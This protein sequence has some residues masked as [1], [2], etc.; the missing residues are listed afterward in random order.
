MELSLTILI[1]IIT[2]A[3]SVIAF[4]NKTVEDDLIFYPPAITIRKQWYRF[5]TC[6]FIHADI[7]HLAFNMLS[8]YFFGTLVEP[9]F[10]KLFVNE[11]RFLYIILYV[12]ALVICLLPTYFKNKDNQYYKSLGASGAVSAIIFT[13]IMI[14]PQSGIRIFLIPFDIPGFIFGPLYLIITAIMAKRSNDNINHSAHLWGALY[15]VVFFTAACF[16]F[17]NFNPLTNFVLQVKGYIQSL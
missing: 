14:V 10:V 1:I 11:G 9:V 4:Y 3:T 6:G 2:A 16:A 5:I 13:G 15:G 17:S 12:S 7:T 8:F